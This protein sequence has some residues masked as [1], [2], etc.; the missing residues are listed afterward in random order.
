MFNIDY[1]QAMLP[2]GAP[3]VLGFFDSPLWVD[4][5]P[6]QPGIVPLQNETQAVFALVNATAR[7]GEACAEAYP[8]DEG[9]R[10][11]FGEYRLPFVE[12]PYLLSAS[13]FDKYQLPCVRLGRRAE[14]ILCFC[15]LPACPDGVAA[16]G[17]CFRFV[18]R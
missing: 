5:E 2:P 18:L 8:G 3:P 12:A 15:G 10:C 13:Q 11:L 16:E 6:N 9:W 1:V 7:L 17:C 4:L 14:P